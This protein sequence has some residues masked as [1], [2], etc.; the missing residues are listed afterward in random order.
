MDEVLLP[1]LVERGGNATRRPWDR[2]KKLR[3]SVECGRFCWKKQ[4]AWL[5][6]DNP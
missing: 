6:E 4:P 2:L 1:L 3:D 5:G